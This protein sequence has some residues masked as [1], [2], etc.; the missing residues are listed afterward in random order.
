MN[1]NTRNIQNFI[2]ALCSIGMDL[3]TICI[4]FLGSMF[5]YAAY[6][7]WKDIP[8]HTPKTLITPWGEQVG[9]TKYIQSKTGD[10]SMSTERT[11]RKTIFTSNRMYPEKVKESRT[12]TGSTTGAVETF[13]ITGLCPTVLIDLTLQGDESESSNCIILDGD[14]GEGTVYDAGNART[15]TCG[16]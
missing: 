3:N 1:K 4:A 9:R 13:G 16:V 10:A 6:R 8:L 11:R 12:T 2:P 7:H 14:S 5:L 15:T